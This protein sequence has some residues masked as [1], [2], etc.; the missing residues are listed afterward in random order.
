MSY[1]SEWFKRSGPGALVAAA[2]IGPG[3]VTTASVAGASFGYTLLWALVFSIIATLTVQ[4]MAI[5]LGIVG[6]LGVGQAIRKKSGGKIIKV[7]ASALIFSAIIVGN[8]AYEGGNLRGATIGFSTWNF[9]IGGLTINFFFLLAVVI[10]FSFLFFGRISY[11]EKVMTVFVGL[12]GLIFISTAIFISPDWGQVLKGMF[13]PEAKEGSTAIVVGLIGTTVVP[14]N[15]FLHANS[16][17]NKWQNAED[18][19]AA[20]K[21]SLI[22]ILIGGL[23]TFAIVIT[24]SVAYEASGHQLLD[25]SS[26]DLGLQ[27]E[28]LL[29]SYSSTFIGLGLFFAGLSSAV[30]APLAAAYTGSEIF[31]FPN[32]NRSSRFRL[33]WIMVFVIGC[34]LSISGIDSIGLILFA[35]A[36]NGLLLP[37]VVGFLLWVMNSSKILGDFKNGIWSNLLGGLV[38]LI[39]LYLGYNSLSGVFQQ[40]Q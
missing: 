19:S 36:A 39:S 25:K 7:L 12:M 30:T 3:T 27:L 15:I 33:I 10:G 16:S 40:L 38:F 4:E 35:Q 2:F 20:R 17:K 13:M 9:S 32:D 29:G 37:I 28:P 31:N 11:I 18:L 21:D 24:S 26:I 23:I 5:R 34:L 6:K 22:S 14:Y 1:L 8:T